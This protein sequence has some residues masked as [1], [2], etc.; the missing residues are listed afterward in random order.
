MLDAREH[1][2]IAETII[3][4]LEGNEELTPHEQRVHIDLAQVHATLALVAAT[5]G[6]PLAYE[7]EKP[8]ATAPGPVVKPKVKGPRPDAQR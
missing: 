4:H 8:K 3:Q 5:A 1:Y 6:M 7:P 2:V